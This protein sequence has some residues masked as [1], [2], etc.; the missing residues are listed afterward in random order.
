MLITEME[1]LV[2]ERGIMGPRPNLLNYLHILI[3]GSLRW[4]FMHVL[5][6]WKKCFSFW[7][8]NLYL[9]GKMY[10]DPPP[11]APHG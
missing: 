11:P 7:L 3:L 8:W 1:G 4:I 5:T 9:V 10:T 6:D 2:E